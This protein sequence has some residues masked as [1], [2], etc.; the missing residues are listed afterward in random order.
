MCCNY[1]L[2]LNSVIQV[3]L[4][5]CE[6]LLSWFCVCASAQ[7]LSHVQL[8]ATPWAIASRL[9]CPQN[10]AVQNTGVGSHPL[11][12]TFPTQVSSPGLLHCRWIL[13]QLSHQGE[14]IAI[15]FLRGSS[16]TRVQIQ[17][18]HIAGR[19]FTIRA[20]REAHIRINQGNTKAVDIYFF[21]LKIY[22]TFI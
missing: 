10:S 20:T 8:F 4:V 18:S 21:H 14:W 5:I 13:Y 17:V 1:P 2:D 15:P 11:L 3:F 16:R 9:L 12:Q 19:F 6:R 22:D 7:S